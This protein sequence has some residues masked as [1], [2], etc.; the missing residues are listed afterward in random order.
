MRTAKI[1]RHEDPPRFSFV[2]LGGAR[3]A[4]R[5]CRRAFPPPPAHDEAMRA[6]AVAWA[7]AQAGHHERGTTN[8]SPR[9]NRWT[10][11]MGLSRDPCPRWC[12]AFVHQ[13][14][15]QAGVRLS[16]RL[17][18]P[19]RSFEDAVAGRRGLR[20]ISVLSVR[21]GDI[22]FFAFRPRLKASHLAIVTSIPKAGYANTAEGNVGHA[23]RLNR[24]GVRY[25][26]LAARVVV[27]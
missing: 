21:R 26:V 16:S 14:F 15:L 11:A 25:A 3:R 10:K 1:A 9:I 24:R 6:R 18:D 23:V 17:I 4:A 27:P 12:G 20:R 5:S 13:A 2:L 22:L 7:M 8:C 19:D